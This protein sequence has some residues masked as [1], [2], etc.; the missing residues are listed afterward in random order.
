[1]TMKAIIFPADN[2]TRFAL[3]EVFMTALVYFAAIYIV[4]AV[5][6]FKGEQLYVATSQ[7][8]GHAQMVISKVEIANVSGDQT[9]TVRIG[10]TLVPKF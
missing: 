2:D 9:S 10:R 7:I 3:E 6:Q 8:Q 5:I 1:M 4:A